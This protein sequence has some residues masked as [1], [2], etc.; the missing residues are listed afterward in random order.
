MLKKTMNIK[1]RKPLV[2]VVMP[3]RNAGSFLVEAIESIL[4][5]TYKNFEFIIVDDASTDESSAILKKYKKLDKRVVVFKNKE[6]QGIVKSVT[7]AISKSRGEFVARMDADDISMTD[8]FAKEVAFLTKYKRVIAVGG[9][10]ELIDAS[11]IKIGEKKFPKEDKKI[12]KMIFSSVPMQQP[13]MMVAVSRLPKGFVW[14]DEDYSSA[15]ELGFLFKIF[16]IGKVANLKDY[17][18]KYRI[19]SGNTSLVNPKGT[20]YLTLKTR[21]LAMFKYGYKPTM[22]GVLM[23]IAQIFV[24]TFFPASVIRTLYSIYRGVNLGSVKINWDGNT[25]LQKTYELVKA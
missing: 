13:S 2:S 6:R 16:Q 19:H 18:L 7:F 23:T 25:A 8:R 14:Y 22:G 9:Q 12:R 21:V 15:E 3:V 4:N 17:V 1:A 20:F 5:Q 11:G 10:C 24:V